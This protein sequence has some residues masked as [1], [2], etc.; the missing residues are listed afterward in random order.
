[1]ALTICPLASGSK[2]NAVYIG[3]GERAVLFDAGLSGVALERRMAE[4][5]LSPNALDAVIVSHEHTDHVKGAGILSR[6]FQIPIYINEKTYRAASA[7]LGKV[8]RIT[9]FQCGHT[10]SIG[11]LTV[12]PF[13]ISHDAE[14]PAGFTVEHNGSKLALATDLG[15]ATALVKT[16]LQGASL[17][18]VEANHDPEMLHLGPYPWYLKQRVRSRRGHLSNQ[19]AGELLCHV[20]N[21]T[22]KHVVLAHLS[23]ENNHPQKAW[24]TVSQMLD[25]PIITVDVAMPDKPGKIITI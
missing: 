2:G 19:E 1:M 5:G 21:S 10:F 20:K 22:L 14:D 25:N 8:E 13:S 23:E 12:N 4:K 18:Y 6:R 11:D 7:K 17:I 16:H 9:H 24:E 15:I 3:S